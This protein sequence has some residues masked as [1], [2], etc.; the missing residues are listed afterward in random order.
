MV[1]QG[2]PAKRRSRGFRMRNIIIKLMRP[3]RPHWKAY[4]RAYPNRSRSL[5]RN[6]HPL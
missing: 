1:L 3:G 4:P 6:P 2:H 5:S